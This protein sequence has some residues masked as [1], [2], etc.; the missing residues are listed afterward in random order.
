MARLPTLAT[1][2]RLVRRSA[3]EACQME[4][5]TNAILQAT[6]DRSWAK[7][8]N[9]RRSKLPSS[10]LTSPWAAGRP[11]THA[12]SARSDRSRKLHACHPWS[13][14]T[15]DTRITYVPLDRYGTVLNSTPH[16]KEDYTNRFL[17]VSPGS[18]RQYEHGLMRL[19]TSC[20]TQLAQA[21]ARPGTHES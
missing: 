11:P 18:T 14:L 8:A 6:V 3:V 19:A 15:E 13:I 4:V 1:S 17:Y 16:A 21:V 20:A 12:K 5:A 7:M 2:L 10:F 9:Q